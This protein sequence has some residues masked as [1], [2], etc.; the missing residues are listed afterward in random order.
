[1]LAAIAGLA[2]GA[3]LDATFLARPADCAFG[4][5]VLERGQVLLG[6]SSRFFTRDVY[7]IRRDR[8]SNPED[9]FSYVA[10]ESRVGVFRDRLDFGIEVGRAHNKQ[11]RYPDR[12]YL[13]WDLGLGLRG[14]IFAGERV[15]ITAG[16][17]YRE[18]IGFDRSPSQTH[19]LQRNYVGYLL[20]SRRL[21]VYERPLR[22][23]AGPLYSAHDFEEYGES[24]SE[25]RQEPAHGETRNNLLLLGG[26]S[27][28]PWEWLE[29]SGE[30][31]FRETFSFGWAAGYLF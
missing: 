27:V 3:A 4:S 22:I 18:T 26:A 12:D 14:L 7:D 13:T 8:L 11:D 19:K 5:P 17:S 2:V 1:V 31:E 30:I 15:D 23:Y 10:L 20:F 6:I 24:Y 9:S 29:L 21:S 16:A 25:V 28:R